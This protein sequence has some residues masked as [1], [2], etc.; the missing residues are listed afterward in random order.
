[1]NPE[2][3]NARPKLLEISREAK[4]KGKEPANPKPKGKAKAKAKK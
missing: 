1:M 4:K 3:L 2:N